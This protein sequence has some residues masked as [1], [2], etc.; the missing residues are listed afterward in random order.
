MTSTSPDL[1]TTYLGLKLANPFM[2][3][4]S[5][6]LDRLDTAKRLEDFGCAAVVLRSLFEEQITQAASGRIHHMDV[7]D[8]QFATVLSYFPEADHYALGPDEY[9]EHLHRLK[10]AVNIPVIASLNG[11]TAEEWL[12]FARLIEKAGADALELNMYEVVTGLDQSAMVIENG[13]R[14]MVQDLKRELKIPVALKLSP[15]FT[16]F[17][18]F[19][20]ELAQAGADGLILFNRFLQPDID[21]RHLAVWPRLELSD[22]TELSLRL[23][24]LAVLYGRVRSSLAVTGGVAS[25]ADGIKAI[26]AGADAVQQ[27][28]AILRNGPS[29]FV[30]MREEL[31]HW[32]EAQQFARLDDVRG[33]LSL[34]RTTDPD[35][36]ERAAYLQTLSGWGQLFA[37]QGYLRTHGDDSTRT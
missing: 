3:G 26:L 28:S 23:R 33:R 14:Q 5:P 8:R 35:A 31:R 11:T 15:F 19:A 7:L 20:R 12:K 34:A 13:V 4:A 16:A 10:S 22:S 21:I 18:N 27:V 2:M 17:G 24:W 9:L 6:L 37:Y 1:S 25:P 36:F 30:L 29:Y 32:M